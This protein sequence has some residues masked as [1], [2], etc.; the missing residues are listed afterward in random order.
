VRKLENPFVI[1]RGKKFRIVLKGPSLRF[2]PG[3]GSGAAIYMNKA[4]RRRIRRENKPVKVRS[5]QE[6]GGPLQFTWS[7][8]ATEERKPV[9]RRPVSYRELAQGISRM[10]SPVEL[11][12][13]QLG[14]P[15]LFIRRRISTKHHLI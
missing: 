14:S 3:K 4:Q 13:R 8:D 6:V 9:E 5:S 2:H 12:S 10:A 15:R 11:R 7:P 1:E